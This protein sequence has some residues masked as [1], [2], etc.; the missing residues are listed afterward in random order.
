MRRP[1]GPT[2]RLLLAPALLLVLL[3]VGVQFVE[4]AKDRPSDPGLVVDLPPVAEVDG[5]RLCVRGELGTVAEVRAQLRPGDRVT[6]TAVVACPEAYDGRAVTFVGELVG[7]L[8]HRD[9]G[10]FVQVNDDDYALE[11]GPLPTHD[12]HRGTNSALAVW[13]PDD[14][15]DPVTGLGRPGQRG[16]VVEVAA[17]VHRADPA[18]GGG[19]T[20]RAHELTVLAEAVELPREVDG[21]QLVFALAAVAVAAT[22]F[23]LRRR[24]ARR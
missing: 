19:L 22:L 3:L 9:G 4:G 13:L 18:D 20:L 2:K 1:L 15:L 10:A 11:V 5:D 21:L 6:S 16:D 12:D 24:A 7:D 17:T 8:L 14:L 23:G